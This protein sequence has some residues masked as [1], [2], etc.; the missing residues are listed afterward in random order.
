MNF[1]KLPVEVIPKKEQ[2]ENPREELKMLE[3]TGKFVF[4]G[5]LDSID[6]LEPRQAYNSNKE[7]GQKEADGVPAVFAYS[8][9]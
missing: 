7:T 4:H 5:S 3:K 1:D 2:F 9:R 6:I 8:L